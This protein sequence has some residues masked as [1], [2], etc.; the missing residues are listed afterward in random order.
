VQASVLSRNTVLEALTIITTPIAGV[1]CEPG[2]SIPS[3]SLVH[4]VEGNRGTAGLA[5]R[6]YAPDRE[7][8]RW[9]LDF[10]LLNSGLAEVDCIRRGLWPMLYERRSR[11]SA[12]SRPVR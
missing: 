9:P 10:D 11:V 4:Y 12:R 8:A 6:W 1:A 7:A 5:P 3:I 2:I